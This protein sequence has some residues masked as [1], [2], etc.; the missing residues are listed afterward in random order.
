MAAM[1]L[2]FLVQ[3]KYQPLHSNNKKGS[4]MSITLNQALAKIGTSELSTIEQFKTLVQNMNA[5]AINATDDAISLL[6][7]SGQRGQLRIIF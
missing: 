3:M 7:S 1:G 5:S 2:A 6:Y 4:I